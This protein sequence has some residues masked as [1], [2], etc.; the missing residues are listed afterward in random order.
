MPYFWQ[1]ANNPKLKIQS[2]RF[3]WVCW[4]SCKNLFNFLPHDWKLHNP[5]CHSD[6][7][8]WQDLAD[9]RKDMTLVQEI[10]VL[11]SKFNAPAGD[12]NLLQGRS[13]LELERGKLWQLNHFQINLQ[14]WPVYKTTPDSLFQKIFWVLI[15]HIV[16]KTCTRPEIFLI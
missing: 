7:I 3:Y 9:R 8:P 10:V 4:F 5:Y 6:N 13:N 2:F 11:R 14:I 16:S 1:L 15:N 12:G